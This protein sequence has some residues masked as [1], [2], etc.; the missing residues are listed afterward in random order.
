MKVTQ[1]W[2]AQPEAYTTTYNVEVTI[3]GRTLVAS[4]IVADR[5]GDAMPGLEVQRTLRRQI[6]RRLEQELFGDIQ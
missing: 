1:T 2:S 4:Y 6:M 5:F 3:E